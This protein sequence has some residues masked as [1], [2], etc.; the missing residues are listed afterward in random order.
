MASGLLK[1]NCM[2]KEHPSGAKATR[3]DYRWVVLVA[4]DQADLY[5]HLR[6]ALWR[7]EKVRVIRDRRE[8]DSRNP[9]WVNERLRSH[10]AVVIRIPG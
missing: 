4:R 6:N 5:R 3:P 1:F 10:G 2:A 9:A 7:D 8:N